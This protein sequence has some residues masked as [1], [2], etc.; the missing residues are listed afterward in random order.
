[1]HG[2]QKGFTLIE[3]V[4]VIVILGILAAV[5]IPKYLDLSSQ[6][7]DASAKGV[8]GSL[9]SANAIITANYAVNGSAAAWNLATVV[10]SAQ[11]QGVA[12]TVV[13]TQITFTLGNA[14]YVAALSPAAPTVGNPGTIAISSPATATGW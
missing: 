14:T 6:A 9:R 8:L 1:M 3:L 10:G 11:L 12:T 13:G 7:Q 5:A 4:M 2:S